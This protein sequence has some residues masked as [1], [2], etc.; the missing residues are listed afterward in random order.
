MGHLGNFRSEFA[1]ADAARADALQADSGQT[2][3]ENHDAG[4]DM[5]EN[6]DSVEPELVIRDFHYPWKFVSAQLTNAKGDETFYPVNHNRV[7]KWARRLEWAIEKY[8]DIA[9]H[10]LDELQRN[11]EDV[12]RQSKEAHERKYDQ[13]HIAEL[14]KRLEL[15][16]KSL[17]THGLCAFTA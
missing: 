12:L 15:A 1:V 3:Q 13:G 14:Y 2:V 5:N 8:R 17:R 6:H 11:Y 9:E 4:Q 7:R 16:K 10:D